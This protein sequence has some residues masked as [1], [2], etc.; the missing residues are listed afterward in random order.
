MELQKNAHAEIV[1]YIGK[2]DG[3]EHQAIQ[4]FIE[5]SQGLWQ[6]GYIFPTHLELELIKNAINPMNS[7]YS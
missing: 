3:K 6:S 2:N 4:I 1:T 5:T 7:I